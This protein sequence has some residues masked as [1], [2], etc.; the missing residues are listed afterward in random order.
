MMCPLANVPT[1]RINAVGTNARV[2]P[3]PSK[4]PAGLIQ[5]T[6]AVCPLISS[7]ARAIGASRGGSPGRAGSSGIPRQRRTC[8]HIWR[9]PMTSPSSGWRAASCRWRC[10]GHS[11]RPGGR[12]GWAS[13]ASCGSE[14]RSC[15][16]LRGR[17]GPLAMFVNEPTQER[18][19]L[20]TRSGRS[21]ADG[22][23]ADPAAADPG[24]GAAES[25]S[26]RSLVVFSTSGR[27]SSR[28]NRAY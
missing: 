8:N 7:R 14:P 17:V 18:T 20:K 19:L 27:I 3:C 2:M 11:S 5:G 23:R 9:T 28:R 13:A 24:D 21:H 26:W 25:A 12:R 16:R 1:A 4:T 22:P 6:P 15:G 10:R